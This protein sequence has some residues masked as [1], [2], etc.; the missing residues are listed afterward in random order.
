MTALVNTPP[1]TFKK[2]D[3]VICVGKERYLFTFGIRS[4]YRFYPEK[5]YYCT[6]TKSY[7]CSSDSGEAPYQFVWVKLNAEKSVYSGDPANII[8]GENYDR[9]FDSRESDRIFFPPE[10]SSSSIFT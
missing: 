10:L 3:E 2:G 8:L 1:T 7:I 4:E 9:R 6:V 5:Q